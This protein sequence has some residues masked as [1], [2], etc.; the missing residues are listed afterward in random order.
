MY[1]IRSYY[2]RHEVEW[3]WVRG[4]TGHDENERCDVLAR[5]AASQWPLLEDSGYPG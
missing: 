4:H 3:H 2:E 1:A 5:Q